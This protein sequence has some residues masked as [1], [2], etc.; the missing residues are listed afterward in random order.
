MSRKKQSRLG[1]SRLSRRIVFWVFISVI[2]IETLIFIPSYKQRE[3]ELLSQMKEISVARVA[4]IMQLVSPEVPDE[5]LYNHVS[6]LHD[7]KIVVGGTLYR[8]DGKK[9]GSFGEIVDF[10]CQTCRNDLFV[11]PGQTPLR[12][13][14]LAGGAAK[15]LSLDPSP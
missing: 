1:L 15:R 5:E 2:L 13:C 11:E 7:G 6:R 3:K 10:Q 4:Y 14:L 8:A 9:I 12:H